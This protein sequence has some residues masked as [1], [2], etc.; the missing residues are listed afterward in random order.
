M[1]P[2]AARPFSLPS[3]ADVGRTLDTVLDRSVVGGY[4]VLGYRL[5]RRM[6]SSAD[7]PRLDGRTVVITGGNAGIG[8]AAAEGI[9]RL[10]AT[11]WI[12]ARDPDRGERARA[13]VA[14]RSGNPDVRLGI[15]DLSRLESVRRFA[16][17]LAAATPRVDVLVHNAGVLPSRRETTPDGIELAL[18]TNVVG[19]FLLTGLLLPLLEGAAPARVINVS[20][21][22]MYARRIRVE[23]LQSEG[24]GFDGAAVYA[25]TKRAEVILTEMWA[26]RLAGRGVVVHSMHPGWVETAGIQASLP[27]F[28]RVMHPLLRTPEEG[29]DTIVWLAAADEPGQSTGRFWHDRRE[30]PTHLL[31][32]THETPEERE[33][34]WAQCLSLSGLELP[35]PPQTTDR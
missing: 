17:E 19:P 23:D 24:G 15:C 3:P 12:A 32:W 33:R 35:D 9:A 10:G 7:L 5:R 29:A 4:T 20:S 18:A 14:E 11:V 2:T 22:G 6:W 26:E 34:L 21:G 1:P 8:L 30:R 16:A 31:P 13:A 27:R 25:R 28:H